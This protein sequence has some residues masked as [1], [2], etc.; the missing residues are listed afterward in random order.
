MVKNALGNHESFSKVPIALHLDHGN[1][2]SCKQCI[3][4]GFSSVMIDASSLDY[5]DNIRQTRRVANLAQKRGLSTE[6]ELGK[7]AGVE[8]DIV[9][10][11]TTYTDPHEVVDFLYQSGCDALAIAYGT[12]HG[13][14]KGNTAKLKLEIIA[15]SYGYI[16]DEKKNLD[17]FIVGHGSSTVPQ[18]LVDEVN[19]YGGTLSETSGVSEDMLKAAIHA[20]VRKVNIDTDLR[21]GITAEVRKYLKET[22]RVINKSELLSQV[23]DCFT[24][25]TKVLDSSGN[26]IEPGK[27]VDPRSYLQT[28]VDKD[29][30][31]LREDY[32]KQGD[33]HFTRLMHRIE[34][35]VADHV[36]HLTARVFNSL[37]LADT[38]KNN[39]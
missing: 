21:L 16:T 23:N 22:P 29:T 1:Y 7:L 4:D 26:Q 15:D 6:A 13:A 17:W 3:G 39:N 37:E 27:L 10:D 18:H 35:R 31:I 24:G 2:E 25:K 20:G 34:E 11:K 19:A 30:R 9:N 36:F 12:S 14:N 5:E 32:A 28:L 38:V 8:E 33:F